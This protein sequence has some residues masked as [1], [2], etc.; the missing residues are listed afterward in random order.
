MAAEQLTLRL[1]SMESTIAHHNIRNAT[2][3]SDEWIELTSVA[4]HLATLKLYIDDTAMVTIME[5]R[6]KAR[7]LKAEYG[8]DLLIVDYLQLLQG[9]RMH[10]NNNTVLVPVS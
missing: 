3:T 4:A 2:I 8:L 7:K 6:A 9:S 10:E 1:L 5:L